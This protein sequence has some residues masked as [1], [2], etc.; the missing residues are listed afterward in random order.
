MKLYSSKTI[1]RCK[2]IS[3]HS[4]RIA[5]SVPLINNNI[6]V[7]AIPVSIIQN[8]S[9]VN[10]LHFLSPQRIN[11]SESFH[12]HAKTMHTWK[13]TI[14]I[15]IFT[16]Y[17]TR[18]ITKLHQQSTICLE[19]DGSQLDKKSGGNWVLSNPHSQLLVHGSNPDYGSMDNIHSH[20]SEA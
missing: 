12:D 6:T 8:Q 3:P 18:L 19:T 9:T 10:P 2:L 15:H 13:R 7:D 5:S 11:T 20:R 16:Q 17:P 14:R 1:S 4:Y